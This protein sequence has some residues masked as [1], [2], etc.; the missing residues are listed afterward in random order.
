MPVPRSATACCCGLTKSGEVT[1][2]QHDVALLDTSEY[3]RFK[4]NW[5]TS[6]QELQR[7]GEGNELT[8]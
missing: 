5:F 7:I 6:S 8:V 1:R 4:G 3:E 2:Q